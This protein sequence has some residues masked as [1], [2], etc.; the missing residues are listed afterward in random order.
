[1]QVA[2]FR[3]RLISISS[4]GGAVDRRGWASEP[5]EVSRFSCAPVEWFRCL[6][7]LRRERD[8]ITGARENKSNFQGSSHSAVG[9]FHFPHAARRLIAEAAKNETK[10]SATLCVTRRSDRH[11]TRAGREDSRRAPRQRSCRPL[12]Q[13]S[14]ADLGV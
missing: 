12:P 7:R 6:R 4:R 13:S 11:V 14:S 3:N 2:R 5:R 8:K 10:A 1:M 9:L